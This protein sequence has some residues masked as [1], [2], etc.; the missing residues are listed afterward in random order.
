M[1]RL[2]GQHTGSLFAVRPVWTDWNLLTSEQ[3]DH[4]L[5]CLGDSSPDQQCGVLYGG[6]V[7][8]G[9]EWAWRGVVWCDCCSS[10]VSGLG[11]HLYLK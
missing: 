2:D 11:P 8:R 10:R 4:V 3:T 9:V 6:V 7:C 5:R 1:H